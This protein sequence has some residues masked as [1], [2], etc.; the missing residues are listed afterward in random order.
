MVGKID[1]ARSV[2]LEL[3]TIREIEKRLDAAAGPGHPAS[4]VKPGT[5]SPK[6]TAIAAKDGHMFISNG[7]NKWELQ[8]LGGLT[9]LEGWSEKWTDL[10]DRRAA[11]AEQRD[12]Q[13]LHF[14]VP[15]KQVI[16]PHIRWPEEPKDGSDRPIRHLQ[17]QAAG[18]R[19]IYPEAELRSSLDI[20]P[21]H[22]RHDS[23]W[24][25]SGCC[26][27]MQ[28]LL[29]AINPQIDI[30]TVP[31]KT[32]LKHSAHDLTQHFFVEPPAEEYLFLTPNGQVVADNEH[33]EKTGKH[34]GSLYALENPGAPD[35]RKVMVFGDSYSYIQ[36]MSFV[37]S[38]IFKTVVFLWSKNIIWDFVSAQKADIVIWESAERY[39][40]SVPEH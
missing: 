29:S 20:A 32:I 7:H 34:V 10:F 25:A 37:L 17:R 5:L 3:A 24:N 36:G 6:Q 4:N 8:Y 2:E 33:I 30:A 23:H 19:F 35:G 18:M 13:L 31:L 21:T 26:A 38:A 22:H 14:V 12:V 11:F 15:E 1:M 27:A 39:I 40:V 28:P 9:G 16:L